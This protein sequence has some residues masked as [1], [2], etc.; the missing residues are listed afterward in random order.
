M[1]THRPSPIAPSVC[2][3]LSAVHPD[4]Q[5]K[6]LREIWLPALEWYYSERVRQLTTNFVGAT[7]RCKDANDNE[8]SDEAVLEAADFGLFIDLA[9]MCQK[10][11]KEPGGGETRTEEEDKLFRHALG[12]LVPHLDRRT[13][14]FPRLSSPSASL[15]LFLSDARRSFKLW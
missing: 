12:S 7:D 9:S 11:E 3:W 1:L 14:A 4:P 13:L 6:N 2:R 15:P 10:E 5:A 8:L